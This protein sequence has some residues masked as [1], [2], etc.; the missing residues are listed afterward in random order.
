[1]S[2]G[3]GIFEIFYSIGLTSF[4]QSARIL[5]GMGK[6]KTLLDEATEKAIVLAYWNRTMKQAE[7]AKLYDV[8]VSTISRICKE[9][10]EGRRNRT[11]KKRKDP[12]PMTVPILS[13]SMDIPS[14]IRLVLGEGMIKATVSGKPYSCQVQDVV[15]DIQPLSK[16]S[17]V[18]A[19]YQL[20]AYGQI[21]D[22]KM[23]AAEYKGEQ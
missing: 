8:S 7:L 14:R 1:V 6:R 17:T 22:A 18:W 20:K 16:L 15:I 2:I 9:Y 23:I 4:S 13:D 19:D 11:T 3:Q 12:V 21:T 5:I 10:R